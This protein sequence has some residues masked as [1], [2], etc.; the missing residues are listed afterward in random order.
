MVLMS[1]LLFGIV[2]ACICLKI[3]VQLNRRR[4]RGGVQS[5]AGLQTVLDAYRRGDY[6]GGLAQT[7]G[8][9]D[10]STRT[11]EYCFFRGKM[12]YQLGRL[13]DAE[14]SLR[15]GLALEN[16]KRR[17]ALSQEALGSVLVELERYNEAIEC[18]EVSGR[19]WADRGCAHQEIAE[20]LLRRGGASAEAL[21]RA[22]RA[23]NIDHSSQA[24]NAEIHNLNWSEALATLA[25][26]VAEHFKDAAEVERLLAEA[27]PL[28]G[29]ESRPIRA[30][31]YY[32]AGRAY[33]A[34]GQTETSTR[35]FEQAMA[36]DPHGNYGRLARAGA[37]LTAVA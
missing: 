5:L 3:R 15:E 23:A 16:D 33:A 31:L 1:V 32:H 34:L 25:W 22:R 37:S 6:E 8:L 26:A 19:L 21:A 12:L 18:F 36:I 11:A 9:K 27:L 35:Q 7:E 17:I 29:N 28:C 20:A 2:L 24:M 13:K 10:G 14:A 30:Q 4:L